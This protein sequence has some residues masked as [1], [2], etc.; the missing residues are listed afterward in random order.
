MQKRKKVRGTVVTGDED[1][2]H[3]DTPS[4]L[5][6]NKGSDDLWGHAKV[7]HIGEE[8]HA[9]NGTAP[10]ARDKIGDNQVHNEVDASVTK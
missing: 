8:G 2:E 9:G 1:R 7:D 6:G 3:A 5:V 4:P 10:V